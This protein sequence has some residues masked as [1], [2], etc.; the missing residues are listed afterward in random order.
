MTS[1]ER[2]LTTISHEEPDRVP[3]GEWQ[4]GKEIIEPILKRKSLFFAGLD[5]IQAYWQGRRDEVIDDWKKGLVELTTQL[6]WDAVLVHN[7]IGKETPID[8]PEQIDDK[9]WQ[10]SNGSI[11][12]YSKE[13]DRIFMTKEGTNPPT[14]NV[15]QNSKNIDP[16]DSELEVIRYIVKE[17]GNTHFVFSSPLIGHPKLR[18]SDSTKSGMEEWVRLYEDPERYRE[19]LLKHVNSSL[20]KRGVEIVKQEG[21]DGV[22]YSVDYGG[23]TGPFMSPEM[24][25]KA[26]L[27]GLSAFCD[28]AHSFGLIVLHHACGNNQILMDMIVEAGV[29][30]YQSI[31]TEMDIKKM[32]KRYG[33]NITLWGGVPA[34]DLITST[35]EEVKKE[36]IDYLNTCKPGGGY[37]F[38][39]TH[40]I[41]P[42]AKYENYMAMLEACKEYGKYR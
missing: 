13:T 11:L 28:I 42:G 9:T 34:G 24:F 31:Q 41:M 32:K 25:R 22:A 29:D 18:F 6:N 21:L 35:P 15:S 1:K 7:V 17:L 20:T 10:Y 33:K 14:S 40:S 4:F 16:T 30:V 19:K 36:A 12:T 8:T 37:I 23:T 5:T 2:M 39:T 27:P 3:V 26:I 38:A